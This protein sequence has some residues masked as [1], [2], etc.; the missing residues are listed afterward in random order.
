[1]IHVSD[2][3]FFEAKMKMQN[4]VLVFYATF[5]FATSTLP[6]VIVI[7][8]V[9]DTSRCRENDEVSWLHNSDQTSLFS[10]LTRVVQYIVLFITFPIAG[11]I[12]DTKVGRYTVMTISLWIMWLSMSIQTG[13]FVFQ[14]F[15]CG[16]PYYIVKYSTS[17]VT[18][19]CLSIGSAG[20]I[21]SVITCGFDQ[22]VD[23]S[24]TS[25]RQFIRWIIWGMFLGLFAGM[26][27]IALVIDT[28]YIST[29]AEYSLLSFLIILAGLTV[30]IVLN[31][32]LKKKFCNET[33]VYDTYKTVLKVLIFAW[34]TKY[35]L[36][37]SAFTYSE[38]PSRLDYGK[39]KYGGS[40]SDETVEDVKTLLRILV[41]FLCL[42]FYYIAYSGSDD[43][44]PLE[45]MW[46]LHDSTSSNSKVADMAIFL[47]EYAIIIV[48][49]PI[50]EL[51]VL[52]FWPKVE[53]FLSKPLHCMVAGYLCLILN[54]AF[55]LSI[56]TSAHLL[57]D[58]NG[59]E[60]N[61]CYLTQ[62]WTYRKTLQ[63]PYWWILI[64]PRLAYGFSDLFMFVSVLNFTCS[65]APYSMRGMLIGTFY[66][67]HGLFVG[68]GDLIF[69]QLRY[70]TT[71]LISCGFWYWLVLLLVSVIGCVIFI[72]AGYKYKHRTRGDYYERFLVEEIFDRRLNRP[73]DDDSSL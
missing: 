69:L 4:Y 26:L 56:D 8:L 47:S 21:V 7:N 39:T 36:M 11:W 1:M 19:I 35:P 16:L 73:D 43:I 32:L 71:R 46:H 64:I 58:T 14:S 9:T 3:T 52:K 17:I 70:A 25:I 28:L 33:Y 29:I 2:V 44:L 13:S 18:I 24:T 38:V 42:T 15:T 49:I 5:A 37:R 30:V 66:L 60:N 57:T 45:F 68:L 59:T 53:Y 34:K 62:Q 63:Y 72:V 48:T 41:I 10:T 51:F 23:A 55:M 67:L 61:L 20:F 40:F 50:L 27:I 12:A 22:M 54:N 6:A 31:I 65:Q